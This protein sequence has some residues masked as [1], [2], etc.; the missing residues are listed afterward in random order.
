MK[1]SPLQLESHYFTKIRILA[2]DGAIDDSQNEFKCALAYALDSTNRRRR[3]VTLKLSLASFPDTAPAYTGEFEI[4]GF[5][6]VVDDWP[7]DKISP[8]V[9]ANGPSV[10]YGAVREM[11]MNLTSRLTHGPILIPTMHFPPIQE[12]SSAAAATKNV[13]A[14][15]KPTK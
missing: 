3:R 1:P 8:L 9:T 2:R 14:K 11:I 12:E 4:V 7:E 10:L 13:R 6:V 15:V 5:F